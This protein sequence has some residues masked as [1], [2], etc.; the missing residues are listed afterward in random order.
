MSG[1]FLLAIPTPSATPIPVFGSGVIGF[2]FLLSTIVWAPALLATAAGDG[3]WAYRRG[4]AACE[5]N[6]VLGT[7]VV[8]VAWVELAQPLN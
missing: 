3:G 1:L 4:P 5:P 7:A 2:S 6:S 8:A